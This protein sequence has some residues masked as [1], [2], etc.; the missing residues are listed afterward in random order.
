M[1]A[2]EN[3][4]IRINRE[5]ESVRVDLIGEISAETAMSLKKCLMELSENH[6]QEVILDICNVSLIT[7]MGVAILI[8]THNH[9]K[10]QGSRLKL[11]VRQNHIYEILSV[12]GVPRIL[13]IQKIP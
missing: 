3:L 8:N 7:S 1:D 12:A 6:Y 5:T 10:A 11:L 2:T 13:E 4:Q 9:L